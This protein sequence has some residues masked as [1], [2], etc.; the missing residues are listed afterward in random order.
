M[1]KG[2]NVY[3]IFQN[4]ETML[5]HAVI[6]YS[7]KNN[8]FKEVALDNISGFKFIKAD[9]TLL[10]GLFAVLSDTPFR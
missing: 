9:A 2:H 7:R 1:E 4:L 3:F 10:V 6:T 8:G 5:Y